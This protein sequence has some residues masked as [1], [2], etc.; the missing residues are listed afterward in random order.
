MNHDVYVTI[1]NLMTHTCPT[2]P[3]DG[4]PIKTSDRFVITW[5]LIKNNLISTMQVKIS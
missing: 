4:K 5:P 3:I 2:L 1:N